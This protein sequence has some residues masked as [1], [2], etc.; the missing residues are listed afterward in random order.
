MKTINLAGI[1]L[2]I[3]L[4]VLFSG[5][6]SINEGVV[7]GSVSMIGYV[8]GVNV[9]SYKIEISKAD[10]RQNWRS[11]GVFPLNSTASD[12]SVRGAVLANWNT[13]QADDGRYV[14]RLTAT[15]SNGL[16][17]T[18]YIYLTVENKAEKATCPV[19]TCSDL[20]EGDN[21]VDVN[22]T[23]EQYG[24]N[25]NCTVRCS[26]GQGLY[27][28]VYSNGNM[29][30]D[31]DLVEYIG[32]PKDGEDSSDNYNEYYSM[33]GNWTVREPM[34]FDTD[35]NI[36]I[37]LS[38]DYSNSGSSGYG[39]FDVSK[40]TCSPYCI[41]VPYKTNEYI[42]KVRLNNATSVTGNGTYSGFTESSFSDLS[43]GQNYTL[44]V[45]VRATSDYD[46]V[47]YVTA[48]IDYNENQVF[49][50]EEDNPD[51]DW[52]KMDPNISATLPSPEY[53]DLG[54]QTVSK[55]AYTFSKTFTVPETASSGSARM[56]IS[57]KEYD[58]SVVCVGSKEYCDDYYR[59][60]SPGPCEKDVYGE[61]EDYTLNINQ[62][63]C[64]LAGDEPPCGQIDVSELVSLIGRWSDGDASLEDVLGLISAWS[65]QR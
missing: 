65:A 49:E 42:A 55:G 19:W 33:F 16:N 39:G 53:I 44:E 11:L 37:K 41:S 62:G 57:L 15:D 59:V 3:V 1:S 45:D 5:C 17:S 56:R 31:Y 58:S 29:E 54:A 34:G 63:T 2:L 50:S 47:A 38:T 9:S 14:V 22:L 20:S 7:N 25:M 12:A 18:D 28:V 35:E 46:V 30:L 24:N 48:W 6:S 27:A 36:D 60:M 8:H 21:K 64:D 51:Y 52:D 26:C 13:S 10:D 40:I 61:I 32:I 4:A 23:K 43:A